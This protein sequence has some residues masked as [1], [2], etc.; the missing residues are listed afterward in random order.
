MI[1]CFLLL[2]EAVLMTCRINTKS[3]QRRTT[4]VL[5]GAEILMLAVLS[6]LSIVQWGFRYYALV[7]VLVVSVTVSIVQL[8][9]REKQRLVFQRARIIRRA[10]GMSVLLLIVSLPAIVFPEYKPLPS[11]G[12]YQIKTEARHFTDESRAETYGTQGG[13]RTL[14]VEFWYPEILQGSFPLVIFSH[15]AFGTRTSN[16]TLFRELASN[17]YV[18]CSIDHTY[19]CLYTVDE[20]GQSQLIDFGYMSEMSRENAKKDKLNSLALYKKWMGTRVSDI[21]FVI[22]V[23]AFHTR[24]APSDELYELVDIENIGVIGH[25]LG[26]SAALGIGRLRS[27]IGAVIAL[28]SPFLCD[29]LDVENDS[30]V[31]ENP[32]YPTPILNVYSDSSWT[33]LAQWPQYAQN[34]RMLSGQ[35]NNSYNV[36]IEGV[37]H[38]SLTDLSLSSP[39]LTRILNGQNSSVNAEDC[40]ARINEICLSFF[41]RYLKMA[42]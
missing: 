38:L 33:H 6:V 16:E 9:R 42:R 18:V 40:L 14:A 39:L 37:G 25:S 32:E 4:V 13:A 8:L 10:V 19:Q 17:G 2:L 29:I 3:I 15:G 28:E 5:R 22:D 34:V 1:I 11:T 24:S 41:N 12:K 23:I 35:D 27:D 21:N 26:G 36:H 7:G 20:N 30:F 31:F